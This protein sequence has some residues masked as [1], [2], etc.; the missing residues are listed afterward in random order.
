MPKA[1]RAAES[2][3]IVSSVYVQ[4]RAWVRAVR[5]RPGC[6]LPFVLTRHRLQSMR[7]FPC[8]PSSIAPAFCVKGPTPP[9]RARS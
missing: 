2:H 5:L 8:R 3:V 7:T 9:W 6:D 4:W 1:C